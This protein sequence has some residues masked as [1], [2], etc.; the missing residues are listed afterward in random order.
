MEPRT[1]SGTGTSR[2]RNARAAGRNADDLVGPTDI[3]EPIGQT[4][5]PSVREGPSAFHPQPS[6]GLVD[7]MKERATTQL[8]TQKDRATDGIGTLAQTVRQTTE[9]LRDEQHE[10]VA[11]YVEKAAEQLERLS[12]S[13]R[14]KDVNEL[15]QDA[16]RLARRRP[17]LF[18]GGSFALG[19]LAARFL[20]SSRKDETP[21]S[22][23]P[24]AY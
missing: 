1:S 5:P 12:N 11:E 21:A 4:F 8:T 6:T 24:G 2:T 3:T 23:L 9:R 22:E 10:T 20:K 18:I 19:L 16:E 7:R 13:L 17:A 15:L 14:E